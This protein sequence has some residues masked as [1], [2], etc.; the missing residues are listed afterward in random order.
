MNRNL[1]AQRLA[2]MEAILWD[3]QKAARFHCVLKKGKKNLEFYPS[4]LTSL[5]QAGC[6]S[7]PDRADRALKCL[8]VRDSGQAWHPGG[9][10]FSSLLAV[11]VLA[12]KSLRPLGVTVR[13]DGSGGADLPSRGPRVL[14]SFSHHTR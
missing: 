2:A 8:E 3:K 4:N 6:F 12:C 11:P 14:D 13:Q 10:T 5:W 9:R 1:W 7:D